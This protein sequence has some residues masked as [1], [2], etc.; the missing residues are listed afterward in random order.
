MIRIKKLNL[1][2]KVSKKEK[3]EIFNDPNFRVG[4]EFEI[5]S[6]VSLFSFSKEEEEEKVLILKRLNFEELPIR[7]QEK[8]SDNNMDHNNFYARA[9]RS[10]VYFGV[11]EYP[12]KL[13]C[14]IDNR[15]VIEMYSY[16]HGNVQ[17]NDEILD[18]SRLVLADEAKGFDL[19]TI[20][21]LD[22]QKPTSKT[23]TNTIIK[24]LEDI[25]GDNIEV[26]SKYHGGKKSK[27]WRIEPDSSLLTKDGFELIT[28]RGGLPLNNLFSITEN[29]FNY[30]KENNKLYT[31]NYTGF[32]VNISIKNV[33]LKENIDILKLYLF[34][35]EGKVF[36]Y[37]RSRENNKYTQKVL[38][39]LKKRKGILG[40]EISKEYNIIMSDLKKLLPD[41]KYKGINIRKLENNYIE[42]RYM[43]GQYYEE[44]FNQV[45]SQILDYCFFMKVALDPEYKWKEY[46]LKLNRLIN[47][48][49]KEDIYDRDIMRII[50]FYILKIINSYIDL[51]S[52][53]SYEISLF[54]EY[55]KNIDS[56]FHKIANIELYKK[57]HD[58][59]DEDY[60]QDFED[61]IDEFSEEGIISDILLKDNYLRNYI[62]D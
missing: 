7:V 3:Q 5:E 55:L 4:V 6:Y 59:I 53:F 60:H 32:H 31:S 16:H 47:D 62:N 48:L 21:E 12:I 52:D 44:K 8:L 38:E 39:D 18:N 45:R 42:F 33:D 15:D 2:E 22:L 23:N 61:Q 26:Y 24:D 29:V 54:D 34:M 35:E 46:M 41:D 30:I 25:V 28:P 49:R 17:S 19:P 40:S 56:K 37:F 58:S 14:T 27:N 51:N 11:V 20:D 10:D 36:K 57:V 50:N 13:Y 1:D 43:G 9:Y